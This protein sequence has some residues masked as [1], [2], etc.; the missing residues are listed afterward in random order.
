VI[1]GFRG[2]AAKLI[3]EGRRVPKGF[4]INDQWRTVFRWTP[5]GPDDVEIV[6]YH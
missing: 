4:R 5:S 2:S 3:L 6:D 1:R